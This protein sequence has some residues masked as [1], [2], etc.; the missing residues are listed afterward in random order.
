M[1]EPAI[2]VEVLIENPAWRAVPRIKSLAIRAATA[3]LSGL[4]PAGLRVGVCVALVN[5]RAIARLNHDFRGL[6]KPTDVLAFPQL[7]G[8]LRGI[9]ARLRASR[10]KRERIALGDVVVAF[11]TSAKGAR[12]AKLSPADHV[13][14]LVVHGTLHLLGHD[15]GAPAETK[16]MRVL[17]C[18][19]LTEL[20]I[21]DPYRAPS[22]AVRP[23]TKVKRARR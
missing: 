4:I 6:A 21:A 10:D 14:H 13:A 22:N 11:A 7:P 23:K 1:S 16:R 9:A 2:E 5:D 8:N 3:A 17:E 19:A 18:A 20:G 15:H 12:A